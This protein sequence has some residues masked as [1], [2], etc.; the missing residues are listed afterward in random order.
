[1]R[2]SLS[3]KVIGGFTTAFLLIVVIAGVAYWSTTRL[4]YST[5]RVAA[6]DATGLQVEQTL[7]H[8]QDVETGLRGY[9]ISGDTGHLAPYYTARGNVD[10]DLE[11]LHA[12]G[13]SRATRS[14]G[15]RWSP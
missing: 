2:I 13:A 9:V 6:S 8:L 15:S 14:P 7:S 10:S 1:M 12:A 5:D 11:E 3:Q 4:A